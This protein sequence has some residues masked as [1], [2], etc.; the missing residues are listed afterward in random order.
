MK[1][2]KITT[3]NCTQKKRKKTAWKSF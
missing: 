1:S 2:V 3:W